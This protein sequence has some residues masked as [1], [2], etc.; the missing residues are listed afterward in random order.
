MD[1][2]KHILITGASGTIGMA[3]LEELLRSNTQYHI[4]VFD[5]D[6]KHVRKRLARYRDRITCH[7]GDISR[8][9]EIEKICEGLDVVIH[10][11][12]VIPPLADEQPDLA[13]RVNVEGTKHLLRALE[14]YSPS[15]FVLYASSISVYGDR[16]KDP[17]I[18]IDDPL[19]LSEGDMYAN[20]KIETEKL[21]RQ[22]ALDWSIF[23]LTAIMGIKNHK[24]SRLMF[25]MPLDTPI[26]IATPEDTARAF[27]CAIEKRDMLKNRIFNLGGGTLCRIKYNDFLAR[28]FR[29]FG[30]GKLNFPD[31]TFAKRNFHC[32]YYMDGDELER[33]LHFR[34]DTLDTYFD[35]VKH[36]ISRIQRVFTRSV[37][38]LVKRRL[39]HQ[40]EPWN[41]VRMKNH[42]MIRRFFGKK[43]AEDLSAQG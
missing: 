28:S 10:L 29:L 19:Q 14:K 6:N 39:L 35:K 25:H 24:I 27:S 12:A 4:I 16:L 3:L 42:D 13:Y 20:T 26:E 18:R 15:A 30:L 41:A 23:R 9:N 22:S 8:E 7:F 36:S 2:N 33:I 34:R 17:E 38:G 43:S 32:G 31:N 37:S 40:S 11:A 21:L 5:Q 1:K